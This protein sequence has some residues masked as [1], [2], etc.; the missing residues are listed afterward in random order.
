M[1]TDRITESR[2]TSSGEGPYGTLQMT[3]PA[4]S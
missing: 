2:L 1:T 3:F 4:L